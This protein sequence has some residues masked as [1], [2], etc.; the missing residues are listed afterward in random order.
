MFR[1]KRVHSPSLREEVFALRYRAYRHQG[2]LEPRDDELFSDAYDAQDNHVLWAVAE[3]EKVVA[4][5]RTT[6][7]DEK[8]RASA[9]GIPEV[10]SYSHDLARQGLLDRRLVSGN[11]FVTDPFQCRQNARMA[12]ILL[13]LYMVV[14]MRRADVAIA[15]VRANHLP[16]YRRVLALERISEGRQYPGLTCQMYLTACDFPVQI[17]GVLQRTPVLRPKGYERVLLDDTYQDL[18]EVGFPVED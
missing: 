17:D 5:I 2:V 3:N 16:F 8:C 10:D 12:L 14:A 18:W 1:V 4:S 13:R 15:A 9:Y 7:F 11:R 6:W